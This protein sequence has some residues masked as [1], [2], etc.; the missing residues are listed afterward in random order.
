[1]FSKRSNLSKGIRAST[2]L[3]CPSPQGSKYTAAKK[4]GIPAVTKDWLLM[5]AFEGCKVHEQ[6]YSVEQNPRIVNGKEVIL[7]ILSKFKRLCR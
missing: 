5:C 3:L 1:M 6:S 7:S 2:H 4:W